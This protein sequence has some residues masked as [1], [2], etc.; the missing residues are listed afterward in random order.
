MI[1]IPV[2]VVHRHRSAWDDADRFDPT[3]FARGKEPS[4]TSCKFLPFGAGPRACIGSAFALIEA[5]VLLATLLRAAQFDL[6]SPD[7]QPLPAS[8]VLLTP[9]HGMPLKV[10]LRGGTGPGSSLGISARNAGPPTR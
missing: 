4:V 3:R 8:G 7:F 10:T 1:S 2:Y 5:T 9:K 6:P